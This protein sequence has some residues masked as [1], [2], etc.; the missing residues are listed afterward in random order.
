MRVFIS[1]VIL[2]T[3]VGGL[4]MTIVA[5]VATGPLSVFLGAVSGIGFGFVAGVGII[6]VVSSGKEPEDSNDQ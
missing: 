5:S 6:A 3:V 4:V 1:G 2:G